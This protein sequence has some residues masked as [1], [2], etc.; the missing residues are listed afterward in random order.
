MI[1]SKITSKRKSLTPRNYNK[2]LLVN[3][4]DKI[5]YNT[6]KTSKKVD[7]AEII[8][9][10]YNYISNIDLINEVNQSLSTN[11]TTTND[12]QDRSNRNPESK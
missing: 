2:Q 6:P 9:N 7:Y 5:K 10:T 11:N 12:K 8:E 3:Q 1:S 4:K